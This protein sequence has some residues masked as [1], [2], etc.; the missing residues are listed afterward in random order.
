ME[1]T[2]IAV[3]LSGFPDAGEQMQGAVFIA[4]RILLPPT[5]CPAQSNGTLFRLAVV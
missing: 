2:G 1:C 4:E 5:A 3:G